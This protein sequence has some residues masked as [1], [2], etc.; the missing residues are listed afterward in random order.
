M[1]KY[2]KQPL[3]RSIEKNHGNEVLLELELDGTG[4]HQVDTEIPFSAIC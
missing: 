3:G 1:I 2:G 4:R